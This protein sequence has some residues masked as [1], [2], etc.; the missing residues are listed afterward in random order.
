LKLLGSVY[1]ISDKFALVVSLIAILV[2]ALI[3]FK[4][5]AGNIAERTRE[6][7]VL[8]AVGWTGRNVMSQ[9]MTESLVQGVL[10]GLL[11]IS[12]AFIVSYGLSFMTV[13]IPIPWDMSPVPHFL[14]G[15]GD[16]LFKTLALP[17]HISWSLAT[18]AMLLSLVISAATGG[19][20]T[21]AVSRIKPSEVLRHE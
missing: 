20:L 7:G 5:M 12:T 15:G 21:G 4:T 19:L 11:G 13:N 18:F 17:I 9:L 3:A 2:S 8:K 10:G 6:I 1:A 14:P 16:Q